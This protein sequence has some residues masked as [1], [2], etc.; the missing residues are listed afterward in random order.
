MTALQAAGSARAGTSKGSTTG[1]GA[2]GFGAAGATAGGGGK[3]GSS[4]SAI[5]KRTWW[6]LFSSKK[7]IKTPLSPNSVELARKRLKPSYLK[8]GPQGIMRGSTQARQDG[9]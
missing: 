9:I 7:L 5:E 4:W 8:R 6:R 2:A 1:A 3:A